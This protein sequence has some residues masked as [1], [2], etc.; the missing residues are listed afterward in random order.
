MRR[1]ALEIIL[2]AYPGRGAG[3]EARETPALKGDLVVVPDQFEEHV[4]D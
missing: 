3:M 4:A 2:H 1:Q